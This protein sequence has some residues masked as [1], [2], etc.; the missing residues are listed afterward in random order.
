MCTSTTLPFW[1]G[2]SRGKETKIFLGFSSLVDVEKHANN[3][4]FW[5]Q[6]KVIV[7]NKIK[8]PYC[9]Q[10]QGCTKAF[11][12]LPLHWRVSTLNVFCAVRNAAGSSRWLLWQVRVGWRGGGVLVDWVES[13][14]T[15]SE[16]DIH[17]E[18]WLL[19]QLGWTRYK[20]ASRMTMLSH[21]IVCFHT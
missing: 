19:Q 4:S 11:S 9:Y 20:N 8:F 3:H 17:V 6:L 5:A 16:R 15:D 7:F 2:N 13:F 14:R 12:C 18:S 21:E 10:F 1:Q